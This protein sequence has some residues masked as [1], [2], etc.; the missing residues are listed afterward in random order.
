MDDHAALLKAILLQPEENTPR[1]MIADWYQEHGD[2][3]RAE[4]IRDQIEWR[5]GARDFDL[6][7][8]NWD[9][10][11]PNV[12][13][14]DHNGFSRHITGYGGISVPLLNGNTVVFARGF[15]QEVRFSRTRS[16]MEHVERGYWG[17]QPVTEVRLADKLPRQDTYGWSWDRAH[18]GHA[19]WPH[20]LRAEV[21]DL[22]AVAR[23]G[24][25]ELAEECRGYPH[26]HTFDGESQESFPAGLRYLTPE[27]ATTAASR[28]LVAYGRSRAGLDQPLKWAA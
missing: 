7:D 12:I 11:F 17:N 18:S 21:F 9:R 4:F 27:R 13:R 14:H 5:A 28:A 1:L 16:Y 20:V 15:V 25:D 23:E 2:H 22:L 3:D 26:L 10:W 8:A 19:S 6:L 24:Q